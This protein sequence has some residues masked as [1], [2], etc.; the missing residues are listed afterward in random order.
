[1][2][3]FDRSISCPCLLSW[4]ILPPRIKPISSSYRPYNQLQ[5]TYIQPPLPIPMSIM[6]NSS[7]SA[8]SLFQTVDLDATP[9][10]S[11]VIV[12]L[13]SFRLL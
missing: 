3:P 2:V 7:V 12:H 13:R 4:H 5:K 11:A 6:G 10:Q 8:F 9:A 1:M